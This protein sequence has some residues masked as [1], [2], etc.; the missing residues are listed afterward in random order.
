MFDSCTLHLSD[1]IGEKC[2]VLHI[3]EN[4]PSTYS[5]IHAGGKAMM[6]FLPTQERCRATSHFSTLPSPPTGF[7]APFFCPPAAPLSFYQPTLLPFLLSF[8]LRISQMA[9]F[10]LPRKWALYIQYECEEEEDEEDILPPRSSSFL[11][12]PLL[13]RRRRR[14]RSS[15]GGLLLGHRRQRISPA[16]SPLFL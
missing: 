2:M 5:C 15:G 11:P 4:W 16:S 3:P 1:T 14:R 8:P 9:S 10:L 6:R 7:V 12:Y 13:R